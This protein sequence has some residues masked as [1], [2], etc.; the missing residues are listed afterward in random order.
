MFWSLM[1]L[2]MVPYLVIIYY[3]CYHYIFK[4]HEHFFVNGWFGFTTSLFILLHSKAFIVSSKDFYK[5]CATT[6]TKNQALNLCQINLTPTM[7]PQSIKEF[8][9][10]ILINHQTNQLKNRNTKHIQSFLTIDNES[11]RNM[12]KRLCWDIG[13]KNELY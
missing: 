9:T 11:E 10:T 5:K 3:F 13:G 6:C 12:Y 2:S 7:K 8:C 1:L 4:D